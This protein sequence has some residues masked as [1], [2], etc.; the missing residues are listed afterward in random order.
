[1]LLVLGEDRGQD[2]DRDVALQPGVARP[3][4]L[5]HPAFAD[6]SDDHGRPDASAGFSVIRMSV[7]E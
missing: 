1:M 2:L 5:S 3:V 6:R 4:G 7:S